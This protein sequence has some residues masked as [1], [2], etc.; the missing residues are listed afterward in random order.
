MVSEKIM[1]VE[2]V[3]VRDAGILDRERVV[4]KVLA[5]TDIGQYLL[6]KTRP[7]EG[8]AAVSSELRQVF[9]I[10]DAPVETGDFVTVYTKS[11]TNGKVENKAG[12]KTHLFHRGLSTSI[13][14]KEDIP[15]LLEISDWSSK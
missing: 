2:I 8:M 15:I 9:W 1:R 3:A 5:K 12:S 14:G 4:L 6:A 11:G 7:A 10:P 13:W